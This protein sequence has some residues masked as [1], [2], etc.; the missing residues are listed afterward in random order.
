M[1]L[2]ESFFKKAT[3][4][5]AC[6]TILFGGLYAYNALGRTSD[7]S[8]YSD[9]MKIPYA[10]S[11]NDEGASDVERTGDHQDS[12][13]F[14]HMDFYEAKSTDTLTILEHFKTIQQTSWW[15]C[16]VSS[17]LMVMN[18]YDQMGE[19][20]E[21]T[22]S[23]LRSDHSDL[24]DGTCLDQMIEMLD[25][26]GKFELETTYDYLDDLEQINLAYIKE[27]LS[28]GVPILVGWNDWGGHWQVIIGYDTMGTDDYEGD[29]VLIM[30]D[31]F[32]TTDHNQDGYTVYGAERFI[33]N[34]TFFDFFPEDHLR[35]KCFIA[36]KPK[37]QYDE[38]Q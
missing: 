30:A 26:A 7:D 1:K 32:D 9:E 18:Y 35:E 19:W 28:N 38:K 27:H 12:P 31:P 14:Y 4:V 36:V 33:Y 21:K 23:E 5:L 13:Y 22:L 25:E 16:G 20:N 6:T 10:V 11:L 24:H 3:I 34:F 8:A 29:D 17:S 15:S 2:Q 37:G